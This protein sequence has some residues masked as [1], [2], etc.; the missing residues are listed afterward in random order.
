[1]TGEHRSDHGTRNDHGRRELLPEPPPELHVH[2]LPPQ[3]PERTLEPLH[4]VVPGQCQHRRAFR[5]LVQK[6]PC[7][8]E[9]A[10]TRPLGEVARYHHRACFE[11][12]HDALDGIDHGQ[13][14]IP[15]EVQVRQVHQRDWLHHTARIV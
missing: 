3:D 14:A 10:V 13:V 2:P 1:M 11:R 8:L 6:P 7:G 4:V 12:G 9:L 15:A 5:Q